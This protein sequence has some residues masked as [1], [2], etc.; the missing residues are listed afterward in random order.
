MSQYTKQ[1]AI[2]VTCSMST[3]LLRLSLKRWVFEMAFDLSR[4]CWLEVQSPRL[5]PQPVLNPS[6]FVSCSYK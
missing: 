1:A 3:I 2:Y 6:C 4:F 5:F